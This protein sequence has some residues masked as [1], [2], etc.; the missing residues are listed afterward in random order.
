MH[1]NIYCTKVGAIQERYRSHGW[2]LDT[3]STS[4]P[5]LISSTPQ[6]TSSASPVTDHHHQPP[7]TSPETSPPPTYHHHSPPHGFGPILLA[8][9]TSTSSHIQKWSSTEPEFRFTAL[10]STEERLYLY[11]TNNIQLLKLVSA[12]S[13]RHVVG[14]VA[15]GAVAGEKTTVEINVGGVAVV[16]GEAVVDGG[17]GDL[18]MSGEVAAEKVVG[19]GISGGG[20]ESAAVEVEE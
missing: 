3:Q 7:P 14:Y 2:R 6:R 1:N 16:G 13:D 8:K 12:V 10:F 4:L 17:D 15:A 19:F 20:E 5:S 9:T 18:E 11:Q